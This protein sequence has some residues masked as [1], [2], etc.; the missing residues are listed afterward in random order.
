MPGVSSAIKKK[1]ISDNL[2]D[3]P[4]SMSSYINNKFLNIFLKIKHM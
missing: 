2:S 3:V 1:K 4:G